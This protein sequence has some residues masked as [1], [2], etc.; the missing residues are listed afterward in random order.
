MIKLCVDERSAPRSD[1]WAIIEFDLVSTPG[2]DPGDPPDTRKIST[3]AW[4]DN[5]AEWTEDIRELTIRNR[6]FVPIVARVPTVETRVIVTV[7][8]D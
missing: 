5:E 2:W 7:A 6:K 1:H 8:K 3:Y 4:Y